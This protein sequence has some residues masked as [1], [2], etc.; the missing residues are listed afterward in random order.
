MPDSAGL[1]VRLRQSGPIPLQ[2][3]LT[4]QPGEL[5]ALV[6]PSGSGKTTILRTIAG[7]YR[8]AEGAVTCG[9]VPWLDTGAGLD[10][11]PHRRR[12]GLVFQAY[13]LFPNMTVADNVGFGLRV[14]KRPK[15]EINKKV[16]DRKS[17]V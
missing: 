5:L 14:R 16:G 6:G 1:S 17:V 7:L 2:V 9:G 10:L 11:P 8:P 15:D 3:D 4:C 12:A 13:A